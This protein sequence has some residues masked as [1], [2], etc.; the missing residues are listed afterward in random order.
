VR[1]AA[2]F[3]DGK[4]GQ[5]IWAES[6]EGRFTDVLALQ[7][8]IARAILGGIRVKLT[9]QEHQ[10]LAIAQ[11]VD[12]DAYLAYLRGVFYW[13]QGWGKVNIEPAI[14]MFEQAIEL[15]PKFAP[16]YAR[17][18]IAYA[19]THSDNEPNAQRAEK[20]LEYAQ[21]S[22]ALDPNLADAYVA[23][24]FVNRTIN[25]LPLETTIQDFHRAAA[26]SP[27]LPEVHW[28]LGTAYLLSGLLDEALSELNKVLA[29][30]PQHHR[31]RVYIARVHRY[32][33][34]YDEALLDFEHSPD[35]PPGRLWE[36]ALALFQGGDRSA[37]RKLIEDL[38]RQLP[39]SA[40][41]AS[42]DA[43]LLAAEGHIEQAEEQIRFALGVREGLGVGHFSLADYNIASA[44]ALMGKRREAVQW[45]HTV[46][47]HGLAS[48]PLFERDPNLSNLRSDPEFQAWLGEMKALWERRRASL[49]PK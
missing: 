42:T 30:D 5:S 25:G 16:A 29:L 47:E 31:A 49:L 14:A 17:L 24:G 6:Y 15:D 37:A 35:F 45:L 19:L 10:R 13:D 27:N 39:D 26:L 11:P 28:R 33:G 20:A 8:R 36:K 4:N 46:V 18:A 43:L 1:I 44:Y 12:T 38:R 48:Y 3:F 22:V 21:R 2:Q 40:D 7:N 32:Q 41:L 34:K 23:R 9:A